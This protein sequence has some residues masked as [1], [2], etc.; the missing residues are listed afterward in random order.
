MTNK[1]VQQ[2]SKCDCCV[3]DKSR[4]SKQ[5]SNKKSNK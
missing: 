5:K 2:S 4:F 3:A 1:V